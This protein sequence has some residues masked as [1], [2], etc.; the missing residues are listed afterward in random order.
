[1]SIDL[2]ASDANRMGNVNLN[3]L[4]KDFFMFFMPMTK[5]TEIE[6]TPG[7]PTV[8]AVKF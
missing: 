8:N 7:R 3:F 2:V 6:H 4:Q 5:G 1:M